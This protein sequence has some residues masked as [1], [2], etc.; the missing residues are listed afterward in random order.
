MTTR[1]RYQQRNVIR[2]PVQPQDCDAEGVTT[3]LYNGGMVDERAERR[4]TSRTYR[5]NEPDGEAL[6]AEVNPVC[7]SCGA[8]GSIAVKERI[9]A[10]FSDEASSRS[11]A[12]SCRLAA[13]LALAELMPVLP[14]AESK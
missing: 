12:T 9:I 10:G 3:L 4:F 1:R 7:V 6:L 13:G 11:F 8:L 14:N 5:R 2:R